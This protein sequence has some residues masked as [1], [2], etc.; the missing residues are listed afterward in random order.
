MGSGGVALIMLFVLALATGGGIVAL[1]AMVGR[2][3]PP[4]ERLLPYECGLDPAG[5][6]RRRLSVKFFLVAV[7]F[8]IFDVE[9]VFF[10]PWALAFRE[11]MAGGGGMF[12]LVEMGI[13]LGVLALALVYAWGRGALEWER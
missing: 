3:T 11:G 1:S 7:L 13:F 6:P 2:C 4:P 5:Q 10:Y 8:I 12:L 9:V